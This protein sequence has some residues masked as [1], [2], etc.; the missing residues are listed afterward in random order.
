MIAEKEFLSPGTPA[1]PGSEQPAEPPSPPLQVRQGGGPFS[2][3]RSQ[4]RR[5]S[6][7]PLPPPPVPAEMPYDT[8]GRVAFLALTQ[9]P[10][11]RREPAAEA[12]VVAPVAAPAAGLPL[13]GWTAVALA[14]VVVVALFLLGMGLTR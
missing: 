9:A 12:P 10:D 1:G 4:R 6:A 13:E 5:R 2:A 3:G 7:T 8:A 14:A 11:V